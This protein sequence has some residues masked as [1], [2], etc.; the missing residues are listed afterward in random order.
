VPGKEGKEEADWGKATASLRKAGEV[1]W[2]VVLNAG[3]SVKLMLQYEVAFP[4][5]ERVAQVY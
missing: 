5:G 2:E 1:Q 3:R 4:T